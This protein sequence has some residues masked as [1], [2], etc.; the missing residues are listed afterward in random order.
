MRN[1][2]RYVNSSPEVIPCGQETRP[3]CRNG[4]KAPRRGTRCRGLRIYSDPSRVGPIRDQY[5]NRSATLRPVKII[6]ASICPDRSQNQLE[7]SAPSHHLTRL[8]AKSAKNSSEIPWPIYFSTGHEL[9]RPSMGRSRSQDPGT[10]C[11]R[12]AFGP[13]QA[14]PESAAEFLDHTPLSNEQLAERDA[15]TFHHIGVRCYGL[16]APRRGTRRWRLRIYSDPSRMGPIRD[17]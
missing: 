4:L 8:S 3:R 16:K 1:P 6:T 5:R 17:Q 10:T 13:Y 2:F 14:R 15:K 11:R 7:P 9:A 12:A